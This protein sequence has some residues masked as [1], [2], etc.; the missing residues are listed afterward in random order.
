[1]AYLPKHYVKTGLFTE[2]GNFLNRQTSEPYSGPYYEIATGQYFSGVGPQDPNTQEIIPFGNDEEPGSGYQQVGVAFNLDVTTLRPGQSSNE[3]QNRDSFQIFQPQLVDDYLTI[4]KYPE[5]YYNTRIL[6]YGVTPI[7][8]ENDYSVGEYRR[9]FCKKTNEVSYLELDENQYTAITQKDPRFFWEQYFG[10]SVPWS[11][12]GDQQQVY[13]TNL[14]IVRRRMQNLQLPN[15]DKYLQ[16]DY[17][18]FY[19]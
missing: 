8:D 7:P 12:T 6:P 10:F 1:M 17:L 18:K 3:I 5:S 14:N 9:Y 15:F 19:K 2:P 4:K 11:I 16:E 13:R